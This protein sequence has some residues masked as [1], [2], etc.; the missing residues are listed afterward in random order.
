LDGN[1]F[2]NNKPGAEE[3][4][5]LGDHHSRGAWTRHV[6]GTFARINDVT[7]QLSRNPIPSPVH[8]GF[9][10]LVVVTDDVTFRPIASQDLVFRASIVS[11][12]PPLQTRTT[13]GRSSR[14]NGTNQGC[15]QSHND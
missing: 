1:R 7:D 6:G 10:N 8:F 2:V 12:P 13:K 14:E 4:R 15:Q 9:W 11:V 3:H 5:A